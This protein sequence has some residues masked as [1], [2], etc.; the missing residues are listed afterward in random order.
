MSER[1]SSSCSAVEAW[2][3]LNSSSSCEWSRTASCSSATRL[4]ATLSKMAASSSAA[5]RMSER[6]CVAWARSASSISTSRVRSDSSKAAV[7]LVAALRMAFCDA[8][9]WSSIRRASAAAACSTFSRASVDA[10][11]IASVW[12]DTM[13]P[14]SLAFALKAR[15]SALC[16]CSPVRSS[17]EDRSLAVLSSSSHSWAAPQWIPTVGSAAAWES[18]L[19][20][21]LLTRWTSVICCRPSLLITS[22]GMSSSPSSS[23]ARRALASSNE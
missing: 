14:N 18:P 15:S 13:P 19:R 10:R 16:C 5:L 8:A 11:S 4:P 22:R 23:R 2:M 12:P 20:A 17:S 21:S 9:T 3:R 1:A 7:S 6:V